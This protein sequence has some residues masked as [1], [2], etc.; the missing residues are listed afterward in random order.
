M[1]EKSGADNPEMHGVSYRE[2]LQL[3]LDVINQMG[4]PGYFLIV[5]DLYSGPGRTMFR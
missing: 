3:E 2:R 1:G 5:A 4:F